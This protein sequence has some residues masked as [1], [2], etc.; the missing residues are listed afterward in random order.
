MGVILIALGA[1]FLG[2]QSGIISVGIDK[3]WPFF[4]LLPGLLFEFGYFASGRT[5][6][7]TGLLVPGGILTVIGLLFFFEVATDWQ[8]SGYTWPIYPLAVAF[9]LFQ[10]Y[11]A[12][13]P[14][15]KALLIPVAILSLV[16]VISFSIIV[17]GKVLNFVFSGP[18]LGLALVAVG[19]YIMFAQRKN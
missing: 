9:G 16:T 8:F 15:V 1:L 6:A 17:T 3:L 4:V 2:V 18:I 12:T 5:D 7:T 11:I 13:Y 10:L 19:I 14:R